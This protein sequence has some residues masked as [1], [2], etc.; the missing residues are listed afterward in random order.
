MQHVITTLRAY[1]G[2]TQTGLGKAAG[3]TQADV[4]EM[5]NLPPYGRIDKYLRVSEYLGI[6][7]EALAKNDYRAIPESF[8][9]THPAPQYS[10][11]AGSSDQVLGR[12]GEEFILRREQERLADCWPAL[13]KLVLPCFKMSG[14]PGYDILSFDNNGQPFYLEVKTSL[15]ASNCFRLTNNEMTTAQKA[16]EAGDRYQISYISNWGSKK[17][18]VWDVNFSDLSETHRIVPNHYFCRPKVEVKVMT[19]LARYRRLRSMRQ[20]ELAEA[21]DIMP[22]NL[23]QFE[24]GQRI[25]SIEFYMRASEVLD[26]SMDELMEHYEDGVPEREVPYVG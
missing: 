11:V 6:P 1:L 15:H 19:G 23:S 16:V 18:M 20:E 4:S 3:I 22:C 2:L 26:A 13:S 8:F 14:S 5:E 21:L 24:T 25:P 12:K 17:Q 9:R 10:A 7:V